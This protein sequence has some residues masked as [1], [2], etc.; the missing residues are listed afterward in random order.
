MKVLDYD[1]FSR[2]DPIGEVCLPL[3]DVDLANGET[4]CRDLQTCKGHAVSLLCHCCLTILWNC[5]IFCQHL[6]SHFTLFLYVIFV[7]SYVFIKIVGALEGVSTVTG[8]CFCLQNLVHM[9]CVVC[10]SQD[11]DGIFFKSHGSFGV[12]LTSVSV[13]FIYWPTQ[14]QL[15][16]L[17]IQWL[18]LSILMWKAGH[19]SAEIHLEHFWHEE[20][21]LVKIISVLL[22][23]VPH[24]GGQVWALNKHNVQRYIL[25][26]IPLNVSDV[27]LSLPKEEVM[28]LGLSVCLSARLLKKFWTEFDEIF[29]RWRCSGSILVV[30][31]INKVTIWIR[32]F[33]KRFFGQN[34]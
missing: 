30:I 34:V 27:I 22:E 10:V 11:V 8:H 19:D 3:C 26:V 5:V 24:A 7:Q 25:R 2:D 4:L 9:V 12:R 29:G 6:R 20:G 18:K 32:E 14:N 17:Q 15:D 1:R 21:H 28:S 23:K 31:R 33:F 13:I 16:W